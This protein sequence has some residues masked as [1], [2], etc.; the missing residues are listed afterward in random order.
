MQ[1]FVVHIGRGVNMLRKLVTWKLSSLTSTRISLARSSAVK[2]TPAAAWMQGLRK[3][4][5]AACL[6]AQPFTDLDCQCSAP[7]LAMLLDT[8]V[9]AIRP[10]DVA[11]RG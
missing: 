6:S 10:L 11:G 7:V 4:L 8:R 2:S 3:I 5:E 1:V 9:A